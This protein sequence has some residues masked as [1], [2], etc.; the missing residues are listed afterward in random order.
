MGAI[1]F[2]DGSIYSGMIKNGIMDGEGEFI[3]ANKEERYKGKY[4]NGVRH[5]EKAKMEVKYEDG[6]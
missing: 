3:S 2:R 1:Y 6:I 5:G 4:V